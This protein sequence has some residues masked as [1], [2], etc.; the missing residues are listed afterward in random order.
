MALRPRSRAIERRLSVQ[1][2]LKSKEDYG[3]GCGI[4]N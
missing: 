4:A 2:R 3:I 1:R